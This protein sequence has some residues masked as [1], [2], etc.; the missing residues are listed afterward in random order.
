MLSGLLAALAF[1]AIAP[2]ADVSATDRPN[3]GGGAVVVT[4]TRSPDPITGYRILR[5]PEGGE[6]WDTVGF[7]GPRLA[8]FV[9]EG[10]P[11]GVPHR[12][13]V[14]ALTEGESAESGPSGYAASRPQWFN[15]DYIP[16]LVFTFI[17]AFSQIIRADHH[18]DHVSAHVNAASHKF[19]VINELIRATTVRH[20]HCCFQLF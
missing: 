12:Y 3:D 7:T 16:A 19:V 1:L 8:R 18:L 4:W 15:S 2:P 14:L 11:D 6:A 17:F 13:R 20:E 9:D 5:Q 10:T